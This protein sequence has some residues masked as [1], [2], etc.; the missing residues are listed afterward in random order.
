MKVKEVMNY[1]LTEGINGN[2]QLPLC[3]DKVASL[4]GEKMY[5]EI[6]RQSLEQFAT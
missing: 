6:S 3:L 1:V 5:K 2:T 4:P